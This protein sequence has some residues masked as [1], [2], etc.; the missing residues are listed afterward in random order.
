MKYVVF[1]RRNIKIP[2]IVPEHCTHADVKIE[3]FKPVS[4]GFFLIENVN[5]LNI[6]GRKQHMFE[7]YVSVEGSDSLKLSPDL[8]DKKLLEDALANSGMYAFMFF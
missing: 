7:V 1:Q 6:E 8:S 2:V 3:G 4:A 5:Q